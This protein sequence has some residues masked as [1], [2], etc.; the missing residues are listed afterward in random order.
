V[1]FVESQAVRAVLVLTLAAIVF[2]GV[3]FAGGALFF[4]LT[5]VV[6][7][8]AAAGITA[9]VLLS[10]AYGAALMVR[11]K[12][13]QPVHKPTPTAASSAAVGPDAATVSMIAGMA[14]EKPLLAVLFAGLLGAAGTI[15]QHKSRVD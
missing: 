8:W 7:M 15:I 5:P 13:Q 4:A 1:S 10:I 11:A 12:G 6:Q 9:L 3:L 14:R 2:T